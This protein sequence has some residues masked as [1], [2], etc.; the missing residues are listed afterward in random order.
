LR[1]VGDSVLSEAEARF[2]VVAASGSIENRFAALAER[3]S[4]RHEE[5]SCSRK[6]SRK[7][8]ASCTAEA[9]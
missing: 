1:R 5:E 4:Q 8:R 9:G 2:S 6:G 7:V 3:T